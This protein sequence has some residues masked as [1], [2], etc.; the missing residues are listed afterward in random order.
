MLREAVLALDAKLKDER[1]KADDQ[2]LY[3]AGVF[4]LHADKGE[5]AKE[6]VDRYNNFAELKISRLTSSIFD[7]QHSV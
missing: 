3:Y 1:K 5:K 4:L 6:Y 7:I 2:A